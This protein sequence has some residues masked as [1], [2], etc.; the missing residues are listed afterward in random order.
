MESPGAAAGSSTNPG[1]AVESDGATTVGVPSVERLAQPK[2]APTKAS[3]R[4]AVIALPRQRS[5]AASARLAKAAFLSARLRWRGS[6]GRSP[7]LK[8]IGWKGST[9]AVAR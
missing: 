7:K 3:T 9:G 5:S 1:V 8:F 6:G 4:A 2:P